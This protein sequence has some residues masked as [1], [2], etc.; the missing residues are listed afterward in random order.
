VLP[1]SGGGPGSRPTAVSPV[2]Y[3]GTEDGAAAP[4]RSI[5]RQAVI[6]GRGIGI[7]QVPVLQTDAVAGLLLT[8]FPEI[9]VPRAGYVAKGV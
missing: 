9:R 7:G 1:Y 3:P 6:D 4:A 8:P 2:F 5:T